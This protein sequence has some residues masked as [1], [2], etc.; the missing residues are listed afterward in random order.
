MKDKYKILLLLVVSGASI[1]SFILGY[2]LA[3][4]HYDTSAQ[5]NVA[6]L[7]KSVNKWR[8]KEG[9]S[10]FKEDSFLCAVASE[11]SKEI[12]TDWS[13]DGWKKYLKYVKYV[14]FGEN[15]S[16]NFTPPFD[17]LASWLNSPSH[18][19]NL[20]KPYKYACIRCNNNYC[21]QEFANY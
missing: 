20:L 17:P 15:L 16:S 6:E 3:K 2:R 11:R 4:K 19:E 10:P 5:I 7:S 1:V 8:V 18:K 14:D 12:K 21:A 13:H 9:L